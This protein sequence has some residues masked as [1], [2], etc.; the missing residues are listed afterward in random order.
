M[1]NH[2]LKLS[3]NC[4]L[5][6]RIRF[7]MQRVAP[8]KVE[9]LVCFAMLGKLNTKDRLTRLNIIN[10]LD[11]NCV[12]CSEQEESIDH[13]FFAC[14]CAWRPWWLSKWKVPWVMHNNPR[15]AFESWLEVK[16]NKRQ[17]KQWCVCFF[18]V[19]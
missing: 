4:R 2:F 15:C 8:P 11:V 6:F 3:S 12:L 16:L 19:I 18:G 10:N 7:V 13:L 17:K 9:L 5:V 14:K 1:P